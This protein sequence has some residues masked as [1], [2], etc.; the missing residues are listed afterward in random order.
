MGQPTLIRAVSPA[1]LGTYEFGPFRLEVQRRQLKRGDALL[2][3]SPKI[4][5]LLAELV[6]ARGDV[7]RKE[8]LLARVWPDVTVEEGI[9]AVT[10]HGLRRVLR[11]AG[12]EEEYIGTIS[13]VGYR[14]LVPVREI[15]NNREFPDGNS[16]AI[17]PFQVLSKDPETCL[18]SAGL[19]EGIIS[20]L[21]N[22]ER[23]VV[24][25]WATINRL[26]D[27]AGSPDLGQLMASLHL[28]LVLRAS[29]QRSGDRFR[30]TAHVVRGPMGSS[31]WGN[32]FDVSGTDPLVLQDQIIE[33][34]IENLRL[35]LAREVQFRM[36]RPMTRSVEA[37]ELYWQ[38]Q[39]I[40][41]A[42]NET[43]LWKSIA[44]LRESIEADPSFALPYAA[45]GETYLLLSS[46]GYGD[47]TELV[48]K[49]ERASRRALALDIELAE[50]H[51]VAGFLDH[52]HH[53]RFGEARSHY[54]RALQLKPGFAK[55]RY[56][57]GMFLVHMGEF[58]AG[59]REVNVAVRK[60]FEERSSRYLMGF[61]YYQARRYE[62][63][64]EEA[65]GWLQIYPEQ[66]SCKV[67]L[68]LASAELGQTEEADRWA[69]AAVRDS[70]GHPRALGVLAYV[71]ARAGK[72]AEAA[73]LLSA[74]NSS[75]PLEPAYL[76]AIN[77]LL[78]ELERAVEQA[79]EIYRS[80]DPAA[81]SLAVDPRFDSLR[82]HP[83]FQELLRVAGFPECLISQAG[84]LI[85]PKSLP[86]AASIR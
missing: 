27:P 3:I 18:L 23:L 6:A 9:L 53:A 41:S 47:R 12:D 55:G 16:L 56:W 26:A 76:C 58:E 46:L 33:R 11:G 81:A 67:T 19:A 75:S 29:I 13:R 82:Q 22:I 69:R 25:P 57:Y 15:D 45:L 20:R 1:L 52:Y 31:V 66:W 34:L 28:D 79:W 84:M 51:L 14:I 85:E 4:L 30:V 80:K 86:S 64:K 77:G 39:T 8:D 60:F 40:F 71:I 2:D 50:S 70:N 5:D 43:S 83:R 65:R 59:L 35:N 7:V 72:L 61:A 21:A 49:A 42:L 24:I 32:Q 54:E 36:T 78:G 74:P 10:I 37:Y 68:S 17:M 62:R 38:A 63:A 44:Y 73:A 48:P